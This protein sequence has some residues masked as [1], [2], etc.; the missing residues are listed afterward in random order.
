M[1]DDSRDP[2]AA[3]LVV[4]VTGPDIE[5]LAHLGRTIVEERLAA[6]VN[7]LDGV[8]SIYRWEGAIEEEG[9]AMAIFKTSPKRFSELE[10]RV[11]ELHPYD[12]PEVIALPVVEGSSAYLSWVG[13][14]TDQH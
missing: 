13:E 9:E 12:V 8:R 14:E 4:L 11:V 6:C 5:S 7:L 2:S 1:S 3:V 10:R